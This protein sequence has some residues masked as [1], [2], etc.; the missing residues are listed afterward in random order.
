MQFVVWGIKI[1]LDNTFKNYYI[2]II[3]FNVSKVNSATPLFHTCLKIEIKVIE[4]RRILLQA[5]Q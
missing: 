1:F 2:I 3:F 4:L 5:S